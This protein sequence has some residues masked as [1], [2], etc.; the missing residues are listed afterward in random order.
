M[1]NSVDT[2]YRI[3][4]LV[5]LLAAERTMGSKT[6]GRLTDHLIRLGADISEDV[7]GLY[8]P[9]SIEGAYGIEEKVFTSGL[10]VVQTIRKSSVIRRQRPN[11]GPMMFRKAFVPA[12]QKNEE[13][14]VLVAELAVAEAAKLTGWF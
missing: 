9:I 2:T 11:F 4:G 12:A 8:G 13:K 1:I 3:G 7:R 5:E 10:W 6:E 14:I